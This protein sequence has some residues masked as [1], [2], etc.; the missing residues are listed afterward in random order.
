VEYKEFIEAFHNE[1][2]R[3]VD[4]QTEEYYSPEEVHLRRSFE[5]MADSNFSSNSVEIE[6]RKEGKY[7][8][9]G[10][11]YEDEIEELIIYI[12]NYDQTKTGKKLNKKDIDKDFRFLKRFL[13]A[14]NKGFENEA[15]ESH[16]VH[17]L[18]GLVVDGSIEKIKL[19]VVT[20][21]LAEKVAFE[22]EEINNKEVNFEVW[23]ISRNYQAYSSEEGSNNMEID[24]SE[25][26]NEGVRLLELG[27]EN[28]K[29]DAYLFVLP[30][31]VIGKLY[32][33][34]GQKLIEKNI[35]AFLQARNKVNRGIRDTLQGEPEMFMAYNNGLSTTA[36]S[37]EIETD[38]NGNKIIKKLSDWQIVNGGQTTA[39]IAEAFKNDRDLSKVYVQV[40]LCVIRDRESENEIVPKISKYANS[41]TKVNES[42]L[43]ANDE[44]NVNLEKLSRR[45]YVPYKQG[46]G[47]YKWFFERAKG[48]YMVERNRRPKGK[49]QKDFEEEYIRKS[50]FTKTDMAK[51]IN[52]YNQLPHIVSKGA[53]YSFNHLMVSIEKS[54]IKSNINEEYYHKLIG[55]A[56]LFRETDRI[57]RSLKFGGY[58]ANIVTYTVAS[59]SYLINQRL[60]FDWTWKIQELSSE[61]ESEIKNMAKKV[62]GHITDTSNGDRNVTQYCKKEECWNLLKKKISIDKEKVLKNLAEDLVDESE[63]VKAEDNT[64]DMLVYDK[65]MW[66]ILSKWAKENDYLDAKARQMLFSIGKQV[67]YKTQFSSK[68]KYVIS[69]ILNEAHELGFDVSEYKL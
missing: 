14:A 27:K 22:A 16:E 10:Y 33:R 67:K 52:S 20:N 29:Y 24:L 38:D 49:P 65:G 17:D 48:Q 55:K 9:D 3:D 11:S 45:L 64:F 39:S 12:S 6:Y 47:S 35:R 41:Q 43:H 40:K 34:Y 13:D 54:S 68:Q 21:K 2:L 19:V 46:R 61:L 44:Y 36:N 8:V 42:D 18:A 31:E 15:D 58:K 37:I 26:W 66:F 7:K 23:D 60:D 50:K 63:V 62:F 1:I 28:G 56:I 59:I 4:I 30:G 53:E 51:Y 5:L 57:V 69:N 32:N 25:E